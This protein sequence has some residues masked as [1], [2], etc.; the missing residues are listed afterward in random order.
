M[1]ETANKVNREVWRGYH[2]C[3]IGISSTKGNWVKKMSTPSV[4]WMLYTTVAVTA[5]E[6]QYNYMY[7]AVLTFFY[8]AYNDNM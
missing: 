3:E 5:Y 7:Y 8:A 4:S 2:I 6:L 1:V